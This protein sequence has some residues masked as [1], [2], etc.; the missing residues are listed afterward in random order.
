MRTIVLI[1]LAVAVMVGIAS[2][3]FYS[4]TT[5][6]TYTATP[7]TT[8]TASPTT[9]PTTTETPKPTETTTTTTTS[10]TTTTTETV[11]IQ[12]TTTPAG[13]VIQP[14]KFRS[15]RDVLSN[16]THIKMLFKQVNGT[17]VATTTYEYTVAPGG[18]VSGEQTN[19]VNV[20]LTA[21][22][23]T[24]Q[25]ITFWV[26]KDYSTVLKI[27]MPDGTTY[28]GAQATQIG[29]ILMSQ[30][31]AFIVPFLETQNME[32]TIAEE[33]VP[34]AIAGWVI[35]SSHPTTVTIGSSQYKGYSVT[36]KNINDNLSKTAEVNVK[37]AKLRD[38]VW[39]V[40][41]IKATTKDG[42]IFEI[43]LA[44]LNQ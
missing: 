42:L 8:T 18:V 16:F 1:G 44:E 13:E 3:A 43:I 5:Q 30:L 19:K 36:L 6:P 21:P 40:S 41:Y 10:A 20:T 9:T 34:A 35:T 26:T 23:G 4:I 15:I 12:T 14:V 32:Y 24:S 39:L 27:V 28:E 38:G 17:E 7:T 31:N 33:Q 2:W 37:L 11:S 29:S 25:S 22:D